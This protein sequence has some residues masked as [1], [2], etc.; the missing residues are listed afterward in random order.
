MEVAREK[1]TTSNPALTWSHR[2][3]RRKREKIIRE[4][5]KR[6]GRTAGEVDHL[7]SSVSTSSATVQCISENGRAD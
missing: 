7:P 6:L 4:W 5:R 2:G 1:T 3:G